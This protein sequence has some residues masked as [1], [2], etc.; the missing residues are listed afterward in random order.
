MNNHISG[1]GVLFLV[2]LNGCASIADGQL[3]K[4][5]EADTLTVPQPGLCQEPISGR[6]WQGDK[7]GP[8]TNWQQAAQYATDLRLGG[9]DDWRLPTRDELL[10]LHQI[11]QWNKNG[12]CS[13]NHSGHFWSGTSL[14]DATVGAWETY[15][16]CAPEYR[17]IKAL[18]GRGAVRAVRP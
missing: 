14:E 5:T 9:Y 8:L 1:F 6:M 2:L 17:Y 16:L 4:A 10:E 15:W 11:F 3:K 12:A 13:M 18:D 7:S